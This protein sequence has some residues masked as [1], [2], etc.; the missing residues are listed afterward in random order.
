M[1]GTPYRRLPLAADRRVDGIDSFFGNSLVVH[2]VDRNFVDFGATEGGAILAA[3][4]RRVRVD[5]RPRDRAAWD[6]LLEDYDI[7][8]GGLLPFGLLL[9]TVSPLI[10][11]RLR[12]GSQSRRADQEI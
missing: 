8:H 7:T 1:A 4:D 10:A 2:P 12:R 6:S 11:R 9:L 5:S 3:T